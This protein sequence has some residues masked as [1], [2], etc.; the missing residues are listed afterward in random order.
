MVMMEYNFNK[1]ALMQEREIPMISQNTLTV[2]TCKP[3]FNQPELSVSLKT[4]VTKFQE[5]TKKFIEA[6]KRPQNHNVHL[7]LKTLLAVALAV[8]AIVFFIF[9]LTSGAPL[10][11]V[12]GYL[13]LCL[14]AILSGAWASSKWST[15]IEVKKE[16]EKVRISLDTA[17]LVYENSFQSKEEIANKLN[18][19]D[20]SAPELKV[21]A[22][23]TA[24]EEITKLEEFFKFI[25]TPLK[26]HSQSSKSVALRLNIKI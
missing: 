21:S 13:A 15:E 12:F 19:L 5:L 8:T 11:A 18:L 26:K 2:A 16:L 10:I 6:Q 25:K 3:V 4:R 14:C 22:Y 24:L 9:T 17:L 7:A 23:K 20:S 1:I